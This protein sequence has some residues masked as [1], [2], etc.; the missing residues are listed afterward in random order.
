MVSWEKK[1]NLFYL[2]F[3]KWPHSCLCQPTWIHPSH[4]TRESPLISSSQIESIPLN[5]ILPSKPIQK[6]LLLFLVINSNRLFIC[7]CVSSFLPILILGSWWPQNQLRN[8]GSSLRP[9]ISFP[10]CPTGQK[11]AGAVIKGGWKK[12]PFFKKFPYL[13]RE[14]GLS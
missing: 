2:L 5:E 8:A 10:G 3:L 6:L 4:L 14:N 9:K 7:L 12:T 11:Y 13:W 1:I